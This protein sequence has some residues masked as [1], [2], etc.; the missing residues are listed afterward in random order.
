MRYKGSLYEPDNW[1]ILEIEHEGSTF[2]KVLAGWSGGY[3]DGD[4]WR[5]NSGIERIVTNE[6]HYEIYGYS[7]SV[8]KVGKGS[9][10]VR[11]NISG[12][13]EECL[14]TGKVKQIKIEDILV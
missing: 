12:I 4:T 3:L 7:G 1:V 5:F 8:Y 2:H 11:A 10:L 13:L 14:S 9:E 6:H